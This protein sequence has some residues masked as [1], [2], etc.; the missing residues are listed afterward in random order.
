MNWN[1]DALYTSFESDA[2]KNDF[3][4]LEA[5][6]KEVENWAK[7]IEEKS[8]ENKEI[9]E[10]YI[11]YATELR[12]L[13]SR[14]GAFCSLTFSTNT[15]DVVSM[16]H[17]DRL[18]KINSEFTG[19]FVV[20]KNYLRA[21]D[22]NEVMALINSSDL[23]K[24]HKFHILENLSETKHMLSE[25]E[26][27]LLSKL[28]QTGSGAW[29]TLQSK[30]SSSLLVDIEVDGEMKQ[31]PLMVV[32]NMSAN[33]DVKVRKNAFEAELKAYEKN[34]TASAACLNAIKGEVITESEIRGFE[35]PLSKTLFDARLKKETLDAMLEAIESYLPKFRTYYR[36][37][38]SLLGHE[39]GL[40]FYEMFAPLSTVEKKI[41]Y[42]EAKDFVLTNFSSFSDEL[43]NYAKRA[44]DNKWLDVEPKEGKRGGAFCSNLASIKES[45]FLLNFTG[46]LNNV[47]TIAHELGHGFHGENI[48]N[49]SILNSSYPM[50]LAETASIF[51][52]T[53]VKKSALANASNEDKL[54]ILETSIQGYGQVIVDIYSRY[55]FE[56]DL[57]EKRKDSAVS[58]DDL[59]EM[60]INAQRQAYGDG[61][62]Q[63]TLHPYMWMNK[64]HYYYAGRNFYN[65]PYA[66]GL[67]FAKG[68]Y[69]KYLEM[70]ESFIPKYNALLQKTGQMS[71][72]DVALLMDIDVTKKDFWM[73]SLAIVAEEVDQFLELTNE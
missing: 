37:K 38:S 56:T 69:A 31:L 62:D 3:N 58:V 59:K 5:L 50:P 26:E 61:L 36:R 19:P 46:T 9:F 2:F 44:F 63:D 40:P 29:S 64:V 25:K 13:A 47:I 65:F 12:T 1:L 24:E 53:I 70:G 45:R 54:G 21:M 73:N 71:I 22:E 39:G 72:E 60:M 67:L 30:L 32:R 10:G 17:M 34:E 28:K 8:I 43:G 52:E 68:L 49:E 57:F 7:A 33:P 41:T 27:V 66:F 55:L 42:D 48:F 15:K 11:K 14:I 23:L 4:R 20:F 16:K 6:Q 35:S 18:D 51:C